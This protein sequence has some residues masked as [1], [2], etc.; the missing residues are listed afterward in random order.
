VTASFFPEVP[1]DVLRP[2]L[3]RYHRAGVWARTTTLSKPGFERLA[4]S[5][6]AGGFIKHR[7][8]YEACIHDF[9]GTR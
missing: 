7:A 9:G 2:A 5:L 3:E 8:T 1:P 6:H 4:H